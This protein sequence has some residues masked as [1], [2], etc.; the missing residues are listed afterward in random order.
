MTD[1]HSTLGADADDVDPDI[2]RFADANNA[3]Y[4]AVDGL[5]ELS[6]DQRRA[7]AE[8]VRAPWTAGGPTMAETRELNIAGRRAR[9]HRPV[10]DRGLPVLFYI[11]GGGWTMFS[12]DTHDRLMREYASRAG[13]N[14]VG[15][16]YSL[17]PEHKFPVAL[18]ECAAAIAELRDQAGTLRIDMD[19]LALGGD[20]AGANLS[21]ATALTARQDGRPMPRALM[22]SYGVFTS[23]TST[24]TARYSGPQYTLE[25][26][27][28]EWFWENYVRGPSDHE[29]PLVEPLLAD[30]LGLPPTFLAIAECDI[31]ADGNHAFSEALRNAGVAVNSTVYPGATHS[32]LEAVSISELAARALDEQSAWLRAQLTN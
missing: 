1:I 32:F 23:E 21:V 5:T 24:S 15:I 14:V 2:R 31:L 29:N 26:D 17:A 22:L 16:D 19:R 4:A 11:H 9:L 8:R 10:N 25:A 30:L 12:I 20:S 3:S 7:V 27:E 13:V 18:N 28:M 6:L